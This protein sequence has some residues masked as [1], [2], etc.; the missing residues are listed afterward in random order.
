MSTTVFDQA[1]PLSSTDLQLNNPERVADIDRKH[2]FVSDFLE[3]HHYDALLLQE[4]SNF[5]WFTAGGDNSRC[6][7]S[8]TT[9]A[10]FVT[11]EARVLVAGNVDSSQ[12]FERELP[13]LGFQLKER[14]WH[15]PRHLLVEDLCRGRVVASD[16]GFGR[17]HDVSMHLTGMRLPL[18]VLECERLRELGKHVAHAVEA[19]A[20]NCTRGQTEAEVAGELAHRLVKRRVLP[21]RLQVSADGRTRRYRHW[22]YGDDRIDGYC[23]I[24]A[25]GRRW[26]LCV[27]ATRTVCF[28]HPPNDF[29][30]AFHQAMLMQATGIFFS[31]PEWELFEVWNRVQ[32]V[33]EKFGCADEWQLSDQAEIMGYRIAEVPVVPKS[34]YRLSPRMA[35][36]WHPSVGPSMTGDTVLVGENGF[37]VLTPLE[38]WP[39][40]MIQVK[41]T[42]L[43]RPDMLRR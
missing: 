5:A 16:S 15:E 11:P 28:G 8:E 18:T 3:S 37:E 25:V 13:G 30:T 35:V 22:T 42:P 31:Q 2:R 20:R 10:L 33:Y 21:E 23:V 17:T 26:G 40:L 4:P 41:G 24:S 32:R 9:A 12:L 1:E 39:K 36:H 7:S 6:G 34:E 19:T 43:Y 27:A 29:R 38:D 14:P